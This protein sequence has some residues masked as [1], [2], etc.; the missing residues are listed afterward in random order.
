MID[1]SARGCSICSITISSFKL[2]VKKWSSSEF[3]SSE[4]R[5]LTT[6]LRTLNCCTYYLVTPN[7]QLL[8]EQFVLLNHKNL[9]LGI[10]Q[11]GILT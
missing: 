11:N 4:E 9:D 10:F 1:R 7:L 5:T 8:I 3:S 6:S 2:G